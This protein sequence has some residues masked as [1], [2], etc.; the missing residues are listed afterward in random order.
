MWHSDIYACPLRS[1]MFQSRRGRSV[2]TYATDELGINRRA[3]PGD[4]RA[5]LSVWGP[6]RRAGWMPP[7]APLSGLSR[8]APGTRYTS[9]SV[10]RVPAPAPVP[11]DAV[12][13][14]GRVG[15][16]RFRGPLPPYS[17]P[18]PP[19]GAAPPPMPFP[20]ALL[21]RPLLTDGDVLTPDLGCAAAASRSRARGD[22]LGEGCVDHVDDGKTGCGKGEGRSSHVETPGYRSLDRAFAR[23]TTRPEA[24]SLIQ[25]GRSRIRCARIV[26][27]IVDRPE[28]KTVDALSSKGFF[29]LNGGGSGI[30]TRDTVSGIHTFQACA[31]NHS[32]TP[33]SASRAPG[34]ASGAPGATRAAR[35]RAVS[36]VRRPAQGAVGRAARKPPGR[37]PHPS[38]SSRWKRTCSTFARSKACITCW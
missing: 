29:R 15:S 37:V 20:P 11:C 10:T 5:W 25:G 8:R 23:L 1:E 36:R 33:P 7:V 18:T 16:E 21:P 14:V 30:R 35:C 31:F 32:A 24:R 34:C 38:T 9:L 2:E 6:E 4:A 26:D 28:M 3:L 19:D 22:T 13:P 17:A 12:A 27:T